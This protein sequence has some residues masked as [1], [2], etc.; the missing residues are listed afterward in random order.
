MKHI[1]LLFKMCDDGN[2][3]TIKLYTISVPLVSDILIIDVLDIFL[4]DAAKH[5]INT[6]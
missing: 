5:F 4:I 1:L 2:E 3:G 6:T